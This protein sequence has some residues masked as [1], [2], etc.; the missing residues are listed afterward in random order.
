MLFRLLQ[1]LSSNAVLGDTADKTIANHFVFQSTKFTRGCQSSQC[2]C[3]N[4]D[5]F[6]RLLISVV[7]PVMLIDNIGLTNAMGVP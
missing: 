4:I 7:E 1:Q 6:V 3:V 5:G 2:R